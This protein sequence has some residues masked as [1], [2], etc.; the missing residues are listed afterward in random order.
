MNHQ[1]LNHHWISTLEYQ[2]NWKYKVQGSWYRWWSQ[3]DKQAVSAEE[4]ARKQAIN[5]EKSARETAITN[6]VNQ[7][8]SARSQQDNLINSEISKIKNSFN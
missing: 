7:E 1:V 5:A 4:T 8:A 6:P 3:G 2:I